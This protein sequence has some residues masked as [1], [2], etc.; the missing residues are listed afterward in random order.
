MLLSLFSIGATETPEDADVSLKESILLQCEGAAEH[1]TGGDPATVSCL[2]SSEG[3][4]SATLI[5]WYY[6]QSTDCVRLPAD[7]SL[8]YK[9]RLLC[10]G[11]WIEAE[12]N[13]REGDGFICIGLWG[14]LIVF[15]IEQRAESGPA[16][17]A[18]SSKTCLIHHSD[19]HIYDHRLLL[20]TEWA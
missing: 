11:G 14:S 20:C 3:H 10:G 18:T 8:C 9:P 6:Q 17:S 5:Q 2:S 16:W 19:T 4:D 13:R 7:P 12:L 15:S 1:L